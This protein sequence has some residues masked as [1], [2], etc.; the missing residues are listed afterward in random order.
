MKNEK[1]T[2]G[3]EV[4]RLRELA[5]L[6]QAGLAERIG[7]S[8]VRVSQIEAG[9]GVGADVLYP[10]CDVL[11]VGCDHFRQFIPVPITPEIPKGKRK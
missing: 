9:G 1:N 10:L 11:G 6:S 8:Q 4:K 3:V 5:G 7:I 2:F